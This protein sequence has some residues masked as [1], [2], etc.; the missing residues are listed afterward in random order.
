MQFQTN[1][2]E[3]YSDCVRDYGT[4]KVSSLRKVFSKDDK[5]LDSIQKKAEGMIEN[6]KRSVTEGHEPNYKA[7]V[8]NAID[9]TYQK[10][11]SGRSIDEALLTFCVRLCVYCNYLENQFELYDPSNIN[12]Y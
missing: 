7:Q 9:V 6:C 11:Q 2:H 4:L 1:N 10:L 5:V 12:R 8:K 3:S